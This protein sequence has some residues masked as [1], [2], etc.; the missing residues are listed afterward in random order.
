MDAVIAESQT[1]SITI[2]DIDAEL[3]RRDLHAFVVS[4][5]DKVE[6]GTTFQ[7]G[8][9]IAMLCEYLQA[10]YEGRIPSNSLIANI[11]PQ[12]HEKPA[13]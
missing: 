7:D 1:E 6:K 11:P 10:L 9:H 12:T 4:A 3:L 2:I 13:L 8:W 5:W